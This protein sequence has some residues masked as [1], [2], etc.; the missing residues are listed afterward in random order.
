M[1]PSGLKSLPT[2]GLEPTQKMCED[3]LQFFENWLLIVLVLSVKKKLKSSAVI[4][5]MEGGEGEQR[6]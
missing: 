4:E 3:F 6:R 1:W 2:S 5:V